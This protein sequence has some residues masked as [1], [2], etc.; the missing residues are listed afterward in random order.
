MEDVA[1]YLRMRQ[2][3]SQ[4]ADF[5]DREWNM[6][7]SIFRI[8]KAGK[9]DTLLKPGQTAKEILF[10][11]SGLLRYFYRESDGREANK[12]FLYE[13][14]FSSPLNACASDLAI[15]CGV[16]A[17]EP[18]VILIADAMEFNALYDA[19]PVFDRMGRKLGEWWMARKELRTRAFQSQDA[20]ER[21]LDFI[22]M[23]GNL[24]QRLPQYH[25][26]SYLGITEVSLSRIRRG[27]ARTPRPAP[28]LNI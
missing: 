8:R 14:T 22:R 5:E 18:T 13:D 17:L 26:A 7:A 24:A 27:L 19:H 20:R 23:H 16:E 9:G 2:T 21:Y 28:F 11:C 12:A 15:G 3:L 10:V 25:I 6:L 4:W 1:L